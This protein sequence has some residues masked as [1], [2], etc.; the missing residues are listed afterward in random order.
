MDEIANLYIAMH[1]DA[2]MEF[3]SFDEGLVRKRRPGL[4]AERDE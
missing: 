3:K 2:D 4:A 1:E